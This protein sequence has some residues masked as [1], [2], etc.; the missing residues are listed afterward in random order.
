MSRVAALSLLVLAACNSTRHVAIQVLVPDLAGV[1][2]PVPGAVV[3]ALPYDRDS[4]IETMER[5]A[6]SGR[7][8]TRALDSLFQAFHGPFLDMSRAAWLVE[9]T[10]RRLDSV[11]AALSAAPPGSPAASQLAVTQKT[12]TDSLA[13][14]NAGMTQAK[15]ALAAA[16]DTLWPRI[17]RL[18]QEARAWVQAT[19]AGYDT[20]SRSQTTGRM[21]MINQDTTGAT[22]WATLRLN[23]GA[24]W[25]HARSPDPQDPNFEWYW[26]VPL[27]GDTVR[28]SPA[29]GRHLPRY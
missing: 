29:T 9:Q 27:A 22:G 6:P 15:N 4:L 10:G 21:R 8:H 24:W 1:D 11:N 18:R 23:Q 14:Q 20:L 12:L 7:P 28:L 3:A 26:N 2:T 5:R 17:E 25:I 19:Y 16:R 13:R